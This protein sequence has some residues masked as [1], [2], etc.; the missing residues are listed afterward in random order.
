MS[1]NWWDNLIG[2]TIEEAKNILPD[3]KYSIRVC[4]RDGVE[5][6]LLADIQ[7]YRIDVAVQGNVITKII[8]PMYKYW[9]K[10]N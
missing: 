1:E 3:G 7:V 5:F 9:S 6:A 2:K 8:N 10:D 4:K